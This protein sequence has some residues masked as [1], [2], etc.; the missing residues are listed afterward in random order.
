MKETEL[1]RLNR[2]ELLQMLVLQSEETQHL[3]ER[4]EQLEEQLSAKEIA[5][6][7]SGTLA[8][9]ALRLNGVFEAAD[10]AVEQYKANLIRL[11]LEQEAAV[12]SKMAQAEADAADIVKQARQASEERKQAAD[13]YWQSLSVRLEAFYREHQGLKE[14]LEAVGGSKPI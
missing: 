8:E 5:V 1:R 10:Q 12:K 9:A 11:N 7:E 2:G 14:M 13:E 6:C 4:I 3:K